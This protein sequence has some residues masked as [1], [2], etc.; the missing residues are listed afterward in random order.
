MYHVIPLK[1][2]NCLPAVCEEESKKSRNPRIPRI[3][4]NDEM[5]CLWWQLL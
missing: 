2:T 4:V 1:K 5:M 3:L